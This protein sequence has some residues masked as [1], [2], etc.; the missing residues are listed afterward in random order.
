MTEQT[1]NALNQQDLILLLQTTIT[2]IFGKLFSSINNSIYSM[3]D[4]ITFIDSSIAIN[5]Q[6]TA[7][8]ESAKFNILILSNIIYFAFLIIYISKLV[9]SIYSG[10][11]L[12]QLPY[13]FIIKYVIIGIAQNSALFLCDQL[14]SFNYLLTEFLKQLGEY[15]FNCS[16]TFVSLINNLNLIVS[17]NGNFDMFTLDGLI[18]SIISFGFLSILISYIL[19][20]IL[21]KLLIILSP[22]A[23]LCLIDDNS[24]IYFKNW[25]KF[26]LSL[27][28]IQHIVVLIMYMP[29]ILNISDQDIL[30]AKLLVIGII[31][32]LTKTNEYVKDFLG[33]FNISHSLSTG[34]SYINQ[35]IRR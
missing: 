1:T 6:I 23:I 26:L 17:M 25:L 4:N 30:Y 16:L 21:L 24:S 14:I 12:E 35:L 33:G 11:A 29:Y 7:I 15:L 20:L 18:T 9:L 19:R 8:F 10:Q 5:S 3:L 31:Y 32:S 22:F 13:T 28:C 34:Y 2:E 27:L